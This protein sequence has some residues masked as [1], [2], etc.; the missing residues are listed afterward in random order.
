MQTLNYSFRYLLKR[1]G[2]SLARVLSL[3]LGVAVALLVFSYVGLNFSF[4]KFFPNKERV[5]QVWEQSPKI[6]G[7][8]HKL[9][10]PLA[11][12]LVADIPQ[13]EAAV[14]FIE[15]QK[16]FGTTDNLMEATALQT[17]STLF[18]VLDFG[19]VSGDPHRILSSEG[20]A[21]G[22]IMISERL[23]KKMF[24]DEDPLGKKLGL[25][26]VAGVFET[27]R[28]N[29]SIGDFDILEHLPY[30]E[31][32][33]IWTGQDSY[34]TF[35]KLCEGADIAEVEAAMPEFIRKHGIEEHC[36]EWQITYCFVPLT[37]TI[38]VESDVVQMQMIYSAIALVALIVACLN[39]VLLT[40]SSLAERSRT[41]A[42]MKCNG[43]SRR[44]VFSMLLAETFLIL[45]A[46]VAVAVILITS[47]HSQIFDL[48]GYRISDLFALER[49]WIPL[50]VCLLAF[51]VAAV[52]PAV[53]FSAVSIGYAFRRGGDN[54]T[55]WKK[56]LLFLQVTMAV[57]V[58][59]FLMVSNRQVSYIMNT[60][61]GYKFDR[62]MALELSTEIKDAGVIAD[63]LR[64]LPFVE[65]AGMSSSSP[66]SGYSGMPCVDEEGNLLFSCRWDIVDENYI[67]SMQMKIVQGRNFLPAD[68]ADKVIV[69]ETYVEMRGWQDSPI[70]KIIYDSSMV[71]FEI[72]GVIADYR[73]MST[74]VAKPIV[75]HT[76]PYL[77]DLAPEYRVVVLYNILLTEINSGNVKALDE[78]IASVYDGYYKYKIIPYSEWIDITF[79]PVK[80]MRN[81]MVVVAAVVLLIAF[82]GLCGY[83][84]GEMARRRKEIAVRKVCG[85]STAE[86][87]MVIGTRL[88][89]IVL[90]AVVCGVAIAVWLNEEW[91]STLAQMRCSVPVW[92]YISGAFLV[93]AFVYALQLLLSW[94]AASENPV[95]TIKKNN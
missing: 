36:K 23:A 15:V 60:D 69:N 53:I 82:I 9:V 89:W 66:L 33:E 77:S 64:S 1:R 84:Q 86:V 20:N 70:G 62:L 38:Y 48:F 4:N 52:V 50:A 45:L 68:G 55:W 27:P 92:I 2:N 90:P 5:F 24:G 42:T 87:L 32:D 13:V 58:V 40:I 39:Y 94:R 28:V 81:G 10:K 72:V 37:S 93:V 7:M 78:A 79:A 35:I 11:P 44:T 34:T 59:I 85:A 8:A 18:D 12:N 63:K 56:S 61:Y 41:I 14:H 6:G 76:V 16:I 57:A 17:N 26:V 80:R 73:M 3:S 31:D 29:Q 88:L 22:E 30:D 47:L 74:G 65:N 43:A 51:A 21:A 75:L 46:S 54:R 95:E 71:P 19:V 67:P 25:N 91:L 83:L 49:I